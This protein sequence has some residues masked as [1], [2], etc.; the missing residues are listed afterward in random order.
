MVSR[1]HDASISGLPS[2][3]SS[4]SSSSSTTASSPFRTATAEAS[5]VPSSDST[6]PRRVDDS[7][8]AFNSA[9]L[10]DH[11]SDESFA[12]QFSTFLA[13]DLAH[14]SGET[15][16]RSLPTSRE[17][18][19]G[20]SAQHHMDNASTVSGEPS[21]SNTRPRPS[22]ERQSSIDDPAILPVR[23]VSS[24]RAKSPPEVQPRS[25]TYPASDGTTGVSRS[26]RVSF[27]SRRDY[28]KE[29]LLARRGSSLKDPLASSSLSLAQVAQ[30]FGDR[31]RMRMKQRSSESTS[32]VSSLRSLRSSFDATTFVHAH[33]E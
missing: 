6:V 12:L 23:Q 20:E 14:L 33:G 1:R 22:L 11:E 26:R 29:R 25:N 18:V 10:P 8:N 5:L 17:N 16:G 31:G 28:S 30:S 24:D 7:S 13:A 27:Q 2:P 15:S 32:T 21:G 3:S 19:P 9:P 4:S